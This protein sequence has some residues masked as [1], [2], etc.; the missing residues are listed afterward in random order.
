MG[1]KG[2][3]VIGYPPRGRSGGIQDSSGLDDVLGG[4]QAA[5]LATSLLCALLESSYVSSKV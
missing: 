2:S 1:G 5:C 4:R 3:L